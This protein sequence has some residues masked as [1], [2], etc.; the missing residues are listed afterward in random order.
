MSPHHYQRF[1][2]CDSFTAMAVSPVWSSCLIQCSAMS[3]RFSPFARRFFSVFLLLTALLPCCVWAQQ[4]DPGLYGGL[5]WRMIGP[6][7]GGRS[8]AVSGLEGQPHVSYFCA[9][10]G[11]V[12]R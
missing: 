4:A 9:G 12:W 1:P 5:R 8:N 10:G 7:R 6:F 3:K 11:G 2:A